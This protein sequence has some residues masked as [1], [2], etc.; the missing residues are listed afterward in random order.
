MSNVASIGLSGM[1]AAMQRLDMSARNVANASPAGPPPG[2]PA[3]VASPPPVTI[4]GRDVMV[5]VASIDLAGESAEQ[6]L[7]RYQLALQAL[8]ARLYGQPIKS[9]IDITA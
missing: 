8:I 1:V 9:L 2:D 4:A 6:L 5:A 7:A 3:V